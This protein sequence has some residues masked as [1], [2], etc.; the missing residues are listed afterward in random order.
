MAIEEAYMTALTKVARASV[1]T[2]NTSVRGLLL[3]DGDGRHLLEFSSSSSGGLFR[4][5]RELTALVTA[6]QKEIKA[7]RA[8]IRELEEAG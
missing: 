4:Q 3:F 1:F 8:R 6:Q 2:G 5:V 7:L